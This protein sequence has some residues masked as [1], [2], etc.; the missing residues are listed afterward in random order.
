MWI[1]FQYSRSL[2]HQ[3]TASN[4]MHTDAGQYK[5]KTYA[6]TYDTVHR[7]LSIGE[8]NS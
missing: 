3:K 5:D 1:A 2:T 6:I 4:L 7:T 8:T